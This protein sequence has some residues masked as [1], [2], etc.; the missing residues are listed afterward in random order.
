VVIIVLF[1]LLSTTAAPVM[2]DGGPV[3]T[4]RDVWEALEEGQQIAVV[5]L[6]ADG[7]VTTDLFISL[8]D[9]SRSSITRVCLTKSLSSCRWAGVRPILTC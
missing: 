8:I 3:I 4:D 5:T 1:I 9:L 6:D 7:I 2:A